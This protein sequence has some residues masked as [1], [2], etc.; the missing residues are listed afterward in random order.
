MFGA[1]P[2]EGERIASFGIHAEIEGD[3]GRVASSFDK[4]SH[5]ARPF[6]IR[7]AEVIYRDSEKIL[8]LLL[9]CADLFLRFGLRNCGQI[10]MAESVRA[11]LLAGGKPITHV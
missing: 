7:I 1:D 8:Q 9:R 4:V 3:G 2:A 6:T 10:Y 11:D 5:P